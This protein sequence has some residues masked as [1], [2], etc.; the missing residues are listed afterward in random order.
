M[1]SRGGG[2]DDEQNANRVSKVDGTF[3]LQAMAFL[4]GVE[5]DEIHAFALSSGDLDSLPACE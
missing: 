3:D 2:S 4:L 1:N 5:V